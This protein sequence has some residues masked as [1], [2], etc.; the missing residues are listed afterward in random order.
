L[1]VSSLTGVVWRKSSRSGAYNDCVEISFGRTSVALR[2]SK[3]PH[4][5]ILCFDPNKWAVFLS[6]AKQAS[7]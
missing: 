7:Q 2:D 1:T 4:G 3:N 6:S 5:G